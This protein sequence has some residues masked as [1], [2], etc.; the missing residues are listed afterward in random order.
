MSP[1]SSHPA[2]DRFETE[3]LLRLERGEPLGEHFATCPD[4]LAARE[5]Y[6]RLRQ[7]LAAAAAEEEPP[8]DWEARVWARIARKK[9]QPRWIW[10][11]AP[12]G[13]A[14]LA[15]MLFL[16]PPRTP[17]AASLTQEVT[18]GATTARA[19]GARPGDRLSLRAETAAA[20]Y[21][22]LRVYRNRDELMLRCPGAETCSR[23]DGALTASLV[24][25]S[26]GT[27]QALLLLG[28]QPPSPPGRGLDPD[29]GAAVEQGAQVLLGEEVSVR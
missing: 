22:E 29:A 19:A 2:C 20:P 8:G 3:G 5:V 12:V 26:V 24:L 14:A 10:F 21:A 25:P 27:Y 11:L 13:A 28:D 18:S 16:V 15:A 7:D 1:Q 9:R 23:E 17:T 6:T 4:C